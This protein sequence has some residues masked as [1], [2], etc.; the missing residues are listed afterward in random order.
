MSKKMSI[1]FIRSSFEEEGYELL[2]KEYFNSSKPLN[3]R[4]NNGHEYQVSWNKWRSGRRCP[5]CNP[6]GRVRKRTMDSIKSE[7]A[8]EDYELLTE[9]EY[10]G[11]KQKLLCRCPKGHEY[12]TSWDA[13]KYKGHRCSVCSG[14][15]RLSVGFISK[16]MLEE[17]YKLLTST[18]SNAYS[19]LTYL[20]PEGHK[21]TTTWANW[22]KGNRCPVCS[23]KK[24]H[25]IHHIKNVFESENYKLLSKDYYNCKQKLE[26]E[27]SNGH[28]HEITWNNWTQGQRCY[29]CSC[30]G[31][32]KDEL[33]ILDYIKNLGFKVIERDR[34]LIKPYELDVVIPGN[35]LAIEYCGLYWHSELCGKNSNYHI[36]KLT[37]C[38]QRGYRLITIFEDE[39]LNYKDLVLFNIAL[40]L[41]VAK[42]KV[43]YARNT[44]VREI[45]TYVAKNFCNKNHLQGYSGS[46]IKLG[47]FQDDCLLSVMTF[48]KPS[49]SKG[50]KY[51]NEGSYELSRFCTKSGCRVIG[52]AS[53][54]L[55]F[56][57]RNYSCENLF[58]Y[59]DRRWSDGNLYY[60][61][62]F[63][64]SGISRPNYWYI[65]N[66]K[67]F[68]RFS[69]RKK[70]YEPKEVSEWELRR[71]QGLNRIWDCGNLKFELN[72]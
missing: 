24:K 26:F 34:E 2:S 30:C 17:G 39:Y 4:C 1:D 72:K 9:G 43:F 58:S 21:G 38:R 50:A 3:Y 7:M 71:R 59:A 11:S 32:S 23:G 27:C 48:S 40:K 54:L 53:K 47:L 19:K 22:Y 57:I 49:I 14:N 67:R 51:Y 31:V 33:E 5:F 35:K 70:D 13:W 52:A 69:F 16:K 15:I 29:R 12:I 6:K 41:G 25:D 62:G 55:K 8:D 37:Q 44:E 66:G 68:H 64:L 18:Y 10:K 65:K 20:C 42:A 61:I 45:P 28:R 46:R 60:S 36:N 63:S 56:F